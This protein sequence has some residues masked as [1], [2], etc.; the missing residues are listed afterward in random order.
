MIKVAPMLRD[1]L[2]NV[3]TYLHHHL[4]T[5]TCEGFNSRIQAIK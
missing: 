5:A 3:L 2:D 1:H 4:T